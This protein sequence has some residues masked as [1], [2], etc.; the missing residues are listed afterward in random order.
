M[1]IIPVLTVTCMVAMHHLHI[2]DLEGTMVHI[3]ME[4]D[5]MDLIGN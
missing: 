2:P 1:D 4:A 3:P 5:T